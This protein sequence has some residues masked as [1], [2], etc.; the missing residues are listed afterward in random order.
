M[1]SIV[2]AAGREVVCRLA[3]AEANI[4]S[5]SSG[6]N[7]LP[8]TGLARAP[9]TLSLLFSLAKPRSVSPIPANIMTATATR[10]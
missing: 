1:A 4:A 7:Q 10:R 2:R 6:P 9:K 8:S 5:S 3:I